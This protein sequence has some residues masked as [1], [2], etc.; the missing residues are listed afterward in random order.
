[1][2]LLKKRLLKLRDRVLH[3]S[4]ANTSGSLADIA[5]QGRQ[6]WKFGVKVTELF[7]IWIREETF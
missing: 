2:V 4:L 1:M 3:L 5:D 6:G 7:K